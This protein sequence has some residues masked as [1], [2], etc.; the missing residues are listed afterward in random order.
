MALGMTLN[1]VSGDTYSEMRSALGLPD[2]PLGELNAGYQGLIA[3]L[4]GLDKSVDFR[5]ANSV[6]YE[7]TFAS[8]IEPAFLNDT[9]SFFDA[10]VTALAFQSPQAVTTINTWVKTGTNGKIDKIVNNIPASTIMYLINA[11]YFK[12]DWRDGFDTKR[13][14]T[15]PFTTP[16]GQPVSARFMTRKGGFR[17]GMAGN[18]QV[19]ELPYGGDAYVM[20][21]ALPSEGTPINS[22]VAGLTT[23]S[24]QAITAAAT[25]ASSLELHLPKFKLT[26]EDILN[27]ELQTLGMRKAFIGG[28]ADFSRLS[29]THANRLFISEVKQ[30]TFVDV[31]EVG[32]EAAAVTS[33]GIDVVSLPASIRIDR[34]FVF[35]IRE[36]LSGT[37]VFL[38]KIVRPV[39]S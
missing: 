39:T 1:G 17:A 10:T 34:P 21:I 38:G 9:R 3:L 19:V 11:I 20:T 33:V 18:T 27:D 28:V 5:I 32:T 24:W 26:W 4:R 31:N 36:R 16:A 30:K 35:A 13:T 37:V 6:W 14:Y 22:F 2:R 12:G 23:A 15:G 8:A 25:S 29:R 7:Q